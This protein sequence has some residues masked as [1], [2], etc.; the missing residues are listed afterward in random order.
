M[1]AA[2]LLHDF[3]DPRLALLEGPHCLILAGKLFHAKPDPALSEIYLGHGVL[4]FRILRR[5]DLAQDL[6]VG[7]AIC[8]F[9]RKV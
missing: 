8:F 3:A 2:R 5:V 9:L 6:Q 1:H 4:S 7:Q